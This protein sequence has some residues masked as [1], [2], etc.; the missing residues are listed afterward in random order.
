MSFN[1]VQ[2]QRLTGHVDAAL[3]SAEAPPAS[4]LATPNSTV[5]EQ[6][7]RNNQAIANPPE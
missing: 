6:R 2:R 4:A 3:M 5:H 7:A 1:D